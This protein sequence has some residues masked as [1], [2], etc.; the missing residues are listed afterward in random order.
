MTEQELSAPLLLIMSRLRNNPLY[1]AYVL[2]AYQEQE[3]LTDEA[4]A[5]ELG[6]LPLLVLRLSLCRRPDALSLNFAEQVRE[7]ADFTLVDE[8]KLA[9]ILRRV[10]AL[11]KLAVR[12]KVSVA[13]ENDTEPSHP[14][15]G[16]L[17]AARDRYEKDDG[18]EQHEDK[19]ESE[20]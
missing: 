8:A 15:A 14:L 11:E 2:A 10:D 18:E 3:S 5:R 9:H 19:E 16:L 7:I 13:S 12:P 17:A 4:L 6:M 20:E 1:M